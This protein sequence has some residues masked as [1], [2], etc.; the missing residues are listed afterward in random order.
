MATEQPRAKQ[1]PGRAGSDEDLL[2]YIAQAMQEERERIIS[3]IKDSLHD[4]FDTL[5]KQIEE[6]AQGVMRLNDTLGRIIETLSIELNQRTQDVKV[7]VDSVIGA[8]E[9]IHTTV[10]ELHVSVSNQGP[11]LQDI[12]DRIGTLSTQLDE[13]AQDVKVEV[14]AAIGEARAIKTTL[15]GV[16]ASVSD[17]ELMV[18]DIRRQIQTLVASRSR[19]APS[20]DD[21]A[22]DPHALQMSFLDGIEAADLRNTTVELFRG[23]VADPRHIPDAMKLHAAWDAAARRLIANINAEAPGPSRAGRREAVR[24]MPDE[25]EQVLRKVRHTA[26]VLVAALP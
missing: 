2:T 26:D 6:Q 5:S 22:V 1:A 12:R 19:W 16:Q 20:Q 4:R 13:R 15:G 3:S 21:S 11:V 25:L 23:H 14:D 7:E 17:Q 10:R 9:A 8:A 18:H 24:S